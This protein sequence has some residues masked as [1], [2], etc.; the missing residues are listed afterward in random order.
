MLNILSLIVKRYY[1]KPFIHVYFNFPVKFTY[2]V[3]KQQQQQ[4][5][6]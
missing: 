4:Q 2:L 3:C 1:I 6:A 5:Q